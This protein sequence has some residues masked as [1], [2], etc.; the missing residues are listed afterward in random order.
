MKSV[1]FISAAAAL[2]VI[3][4][5]TPNALLKIF[6]FFDIILSGWT[7][8]P[9]WLSWVLN[10][11]IAGVAVQLSFLELKKGA[12]A[13]VRMLP[14]T[15]VAI[16]FFAFFIIGVN[17]TP[18]DHFAPK[19]AAIAANASLSS[20]WNSLRREVEKGNIVNPKG[21]HDEY[22]LLYRE[23]RASRRFYQAETAIKTAIRIN[24]NSEAYKEY[25]N[26]LSYWEDERKKPAA[27]PPQPISSPA[28]PP[29]SASAAP[30]AP[31]P[32]LPK[33]SMPQ[34]RV[35]A[36]GNKEITLDGV[37]F[38]F[39]PGGAFDMGCFNPDDRELHDDA[40][41]V[42]IVVLS[43]FWISAS[44]IPE[45]RYKGNTSLYPARNISWSNARQFAQAFGKKHGLNCDLPTEA[46]WEYAARNRGQKIIFPSN[47]GDDNQKPELD[48]FPDAVP[49][50]SGAP[51]PL[52]LRH[53]AGNVWE[54]CRDTY[55]KSFYAENSNGVRDPLCQKASSEA[56][57]RGGSF[58]DG[59]N[60][61]KTYAR[62]YKQKTAADPSVGFRL[63]L[64][65]LQY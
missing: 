5:T 52:S 58:K 25:W 13:W 65:K 45:S 3:I 14:I 20:K 6:A 29:D 64:E 46:Q 61:Q 34:T 50:N 40:L 62:Y 21:T 57:L 19:P 35:N 18:P 38:I 54:W 48:R 22:M 49:V 17:N 51:S 39:I 12:G 43:G 56:V 36:Q 37:T 24:S 1:K 41:P 60:A 2:L 33:Q 63:V 4:A 55:D 7:F 15:A 30:P 16:L 11:I 23:Y 53:M 42:H 28:A 10:G 44:E 31:S 47:S 59:A 32:A 27:T 9:P 26:F 8:L